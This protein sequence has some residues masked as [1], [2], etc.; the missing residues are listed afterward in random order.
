MTT[1][2]GFRRGLYIV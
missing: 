1:R 2:R